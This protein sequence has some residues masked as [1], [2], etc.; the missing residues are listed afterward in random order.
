[1]FPSPADMPISNPGPWTGTQ[2]HDHQKVGVS[3]LLFMENDY[4]SL[5]D[6]SQD[7]IHHS[8]I[9]D[10]SI[11]LP[12]PICGSMKEEMNGVI[13]SQR[14][15]ERRVKDHFKGRGWSSQMRWGVE[16]A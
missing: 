1:M 3:K 7:T 14:L 4:R 11:C 15:C 10:F 12:S 2:L 8:R 16:R 9:S 5:Y 13:S 6:Q